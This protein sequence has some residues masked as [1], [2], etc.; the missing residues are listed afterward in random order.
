MYAVI[1]DIVVHCDIGPAVVKPVDGVMKR[2]MNDDGQHKGLDIVYGQAAQKL[3]EAI[4]SAGKLSDPVQGLFPSWVVLLQLF[5]V[6]FRTCQLF[7][8]F[9]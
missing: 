2:V 7:L 9:I 5:P 3:T 1:L 6:A 8:P 4:G